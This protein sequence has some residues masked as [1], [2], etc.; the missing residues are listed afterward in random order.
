MPGRRL[1]RTP[2]TEG[3]P[4]ARKSPPA[5]QVEKT[6]LQHHLRAMVDQRGWSGHEFARRIGV[7]PTYAHLLLMPGPERKPSAELLQRLA[8][9]F[10]KSVEDMARL[11]G[12]LPTTEA[13]KARISGYREDTVALEVGLGPGF[14]RQQV[15]DEVKRL[16]SDP[17]A[18][19]AI[20]V[21]GMRMRKGKVTVE[22]LQRMR[23]MLEEGEKLLGADGPLLEGK[24]P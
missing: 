9:A 23:E 17:G 2:T 12:Y 4:S 3:P 19:P 20:D 6:Q 15:V 16:Y 11:A 21:L 8:D 7:S 24:D 14:N 22:D 18:A 10:G 1:T 5:V 13:E